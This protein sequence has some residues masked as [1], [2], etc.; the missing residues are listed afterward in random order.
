MSDEESSIYSKTWDTY[1][2][3]GFPE[4]QAKPARK[5]GDL[6]PWQV[7]NT[8]DE[9]Y[10]WPGDEWG[11]AASVEKIL[12][13]C[14]LN[15]LPADARNFCEI[16]SGAGRITAALL[17]SF[18]K[19]SIDC[20]D[21]SAEFLKQIEQRFPDK[22]SSGQVTTNV[23]SKD[24]KAMYL[25]LKQS[26]RVRKLECIYSF[27]AMVHV[28]LHSVLIYM[29]I[30]AAVLKPG[31]LLTMSV[32]DATNSKGFQKALCNAPGVFS[33]GG[34]AGLHFQFMSPDIL[35]TALHAFGF[36]YKLYDCNGRD[37]FFSGQLT[38]MDAAERSFRS[39]GSGWNLSL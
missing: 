37:L 4:I 7:L 36:E 39:A 31:G 20:F 18:P 28:E 22:I 6:L 16:G 1:V 27:D 24:P 30:A 15:H 2:S 8:T 12:R 10:N 32:A 14:V 26:G 25:T 9:T 34:C 11:N 33:Q 3:K 13:T 5:P 23:I 35:A 38:D 29:A 17:G 21:V 19:A